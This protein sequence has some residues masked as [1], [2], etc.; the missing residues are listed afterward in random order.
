MGISGLFLKNPWK[1]LKST[2]V[3]SRLKFAVWGCIPVLDHLGA[4]K[5][6]KV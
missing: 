6:Q 5:K 4:P 3:A 1:I 2:A